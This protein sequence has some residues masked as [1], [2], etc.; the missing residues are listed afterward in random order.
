ML[1]QIKGEAATK[2]S[3]A[4][5]KRRRGRG[6]APPSSSAEDETLLPHKAQEG[7]P[8]SPRALGGGEPSPGVPRRERGELVEAGLGGGGKPF[9][10]GFPPPDPHLSKTFR[11]KD[12][13]RIKGNGC[14]KHAAVPL[15]FVIYKTRRR[16]RRVLPDEGF[17]RL[18]QN[19]GARGPRKAPAFWNQGRGK[20]A[21]REEP[22]QESVRIP[23]RREHGGGGKPFAKGF[24]PPGPHSSKTFN[25]RLG[26]V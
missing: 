12:G 19:C 1:E 14:K 7:R 11:E 26:N 10:K 3:P 17:C 8:A 23:R 22:P 15:F 21:F 13:E 9:A 24:P 5:C 18:R 4:F 2:F 25:G 16:V 20:P 6:A